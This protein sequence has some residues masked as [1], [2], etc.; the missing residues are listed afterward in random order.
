MFELIV[1]LHKGNYSFSNP[2]CCLCCLQPFLQLGVQSTVWSHPFNS[3]WSVPCDRAP[4][5]MPCPVTPVPGTPITP[6]S[7]SVIRGSGGSNHL[8]M[9]SPIQQGGIYNPFD[10]IELDM[11]WRPSP[12]RQ[13]SV[14]QPW[15]GDSM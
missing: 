2:C 11:I 10:C 6:T 14:Q 13:H 3:I 8:P 4:F 12:V 15:H 5:G 1:V 7:C 9:T